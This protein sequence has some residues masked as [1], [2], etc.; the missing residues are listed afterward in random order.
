MSHTPETFVWQ[1]VEHRVIDRWVVQDHWWTDRPLRREYLGL[2]LT[3]TEEIVIF[4]ED[5]E[6]WQLARDPRVRPD[7]VGEPGAPTP[8][9]TTEGD[10]RDP[11]G[12][13]SAPA[14]ALPLN[15]LD[16]V[17]WRGL[18]EKYQDALRR[19]VF[20][21]EHLWQMVDRETWRAHGAEWMGHY[22]GDYHAE[23]VRDELAELKRVAS[24]KERS[25]GAR[26]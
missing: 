1:G 12:E 22:E 25:D 14:G 21:G 20:L 3:G 18:A 11:I 15:K 6:E 17:Y 7:P 19:A 8:P 24:R 26:Y 13:S 2:Y 5:G 4:R 16:E 9:A 10:G 23:Q